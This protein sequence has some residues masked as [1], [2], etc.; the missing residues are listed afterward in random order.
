MDISILEMG[1]SVGIGLGGAGCERVK[2]GFF[3]SLHTGVL[4]ASGLMLGDG[5]ECGRIAFCRNHVFR[6]MLEY[7]LLN[8]LIIFYY[9]NKRYRVIYDIAYAKFYTVFVGREPKGIKNG[10]D[11]GATFWP[12][13][14]T[15]DRMIGVVPTD[16]LEENCIDSKTEVL[17]DNFRKYDNPVLQIAYF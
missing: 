15:S 9:M 17:Y 1:R 14:F 12:M 5:S 16:E 3:A 4:I 13:W 6:R 2:G 8:K 7:A 11:G 10:L